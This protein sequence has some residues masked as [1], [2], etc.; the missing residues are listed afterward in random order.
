MLLHGKGADLVQELTQCPSPEQSEPSECWSNARGR[1]SGGA[2]GANDI[3]HIFPDLNVGG[4]INDVV[5][6]RA[7]LVELD[8]TSSNALLYRKQLDCH[9]ITL[10]G[11]R[12]IECR[13]RSD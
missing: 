12:K 3:E 8:S 13:G 11:R 2:E 4:F 5:N 6:K 10:I 1:R 7:K 9:V